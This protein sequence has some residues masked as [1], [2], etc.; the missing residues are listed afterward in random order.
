M[1][2]EKKKRRKEIKEM[3]KRK[4]KRMRYLNEEEGNAVGLEGASLVVVL[5]LAVCLRKAS[6]LAV[7]L[8]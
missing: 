2:M 8:S 7:L 5:Q 3:M 4:K 6:E 1:M